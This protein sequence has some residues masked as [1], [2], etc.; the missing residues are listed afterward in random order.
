MTRFQK[1]SL[2]ILGHDG[3]LAI[4]RGF[5]GDATSFLMLAALDEH[6][7]PAT[8]ARLER[9]YAL[10]TELDPAWA[11]QPRALVH[12]AGRLTLLLDELRAFDAG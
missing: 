12:E 11:V 5:A 8:L 10:R 9:E 7:A 2:D 6:P 4:Y 3:E 1:K